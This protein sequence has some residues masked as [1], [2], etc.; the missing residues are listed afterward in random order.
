MLVKPGSVDYI[1]LTLPWATGVCLWLLIPMTQT[2]SP[3]GSEK[4]ATHAHLSHALLRS[5]QKTSAW[6]C[7]SSAE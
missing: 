1:S 3:V 7:L 6:V 4:G 5:L 2:I